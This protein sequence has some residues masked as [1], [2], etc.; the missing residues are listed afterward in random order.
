MSHRGRADKMAKRGKE[1][2]AEAYDLSLIPK[3]YS[4]EGEKWLYQVVL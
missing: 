3:K 1:P 2:A 4:E